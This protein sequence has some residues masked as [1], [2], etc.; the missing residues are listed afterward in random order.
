M[1]G[2]LVETTKP[3]RNILDEAMKSDIAA[4]VIGM[5]CETDGP[6]AHRYCELQFALFYFMHSFNTNS[7]Q[8]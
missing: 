7:L 5:C 4:V 2:E 6:S 3:K 1:Q 8:G